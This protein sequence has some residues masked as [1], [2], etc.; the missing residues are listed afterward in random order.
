M[1][2]IGPDAA[3][4]A[5]MR[6]QA[7]LRA[8]I[9]SRDALQKAVLRCLIAAI[10]N[11]GAAPIAPRSQPVQHEVER[12]RLDHAEVQA[13]L[14]NEHDTRL[15]AANEFSRL[16]LDAEAK[17]ARLEATIVGRYLAAPPSSEP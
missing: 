16:G 17:G 8:A 14:R 3:E 7:D 15:G 13:L 4:V 9:K 2:A 10:D 6:L 11:A 12:R 1:T 5:R